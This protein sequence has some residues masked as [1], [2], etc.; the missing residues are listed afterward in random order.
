MALARKILEPQ[1]FLL[2]EDCKKQPQ[3]RERGGEILAVQHCKWLQQALTWR[4]QPQIS[5]HGAPKEITL[6]NPEL[7]SVKCVCSCGYAVLVL[8]A[9]AYINACYLGS[10]VW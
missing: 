3:S 1:Q 9:Q 5:L 2:L 10:P 8:R 6:L 7:W 4:K